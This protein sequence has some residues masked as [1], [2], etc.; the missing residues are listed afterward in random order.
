VRVNLLQMIWEI[1]TDLIKETI[2]KVLDLTLGILGKVKRILK[3][4]LPF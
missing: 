1:L 4:I 3:K 2:G